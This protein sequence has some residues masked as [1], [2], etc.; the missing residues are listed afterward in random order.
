MLSGVAAPERAAQVMDAVETHLVSDDDGL[1][2]LL[3]PPFVDTPHDPGYIKG[4]VAGVRENGGQYTHA[5]LWVVRALAKL[6]RRDR[7]AALLDLLNPVHHAA[8]AAQ[9]ARYQV[10]P[11][12]VAADVYGAPPHVGRG[13][14]TWYTGSSGWMLR[15]ALESVLGLRTEGGE[16]LVVAPCVPDDWPGYRL[17]LAAARRRGHLGHPRPQSRP[18]QRS[19]GGRQRRRRAPC[20]STAASR[21]SPCPT[22]ASTGSPSNWARAR[23]GSSMS[24]DRLAFPDGFLW[25]AATS[26]YQIEGSPLADGAGPSNWH[27]FAHTP[28]RIHGGDT[29]DLACDHYRRWRPRTWR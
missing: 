1:I 16:T 25:G 27:L 12:V 11:Y 20:R 9:V 22:A 17:D 4:Y 26:A 3:T 15:V 8:T 6:G 24:R 28:G 5:A 29:G 14:W 2:R 18:L 10:E 7:A 13:G 19:G 23:T 21:A